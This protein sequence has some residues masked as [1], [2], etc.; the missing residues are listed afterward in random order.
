MLNIN[1]REYL[2]LLTSENCIWKT[3]LFYITKQIIAYICL[4][5]FLINVKIKMNCKTESNFLL[6]SLHGGP[7]VENH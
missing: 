1:L 2:G 4:V 6:C 3:K 5:H 7:R